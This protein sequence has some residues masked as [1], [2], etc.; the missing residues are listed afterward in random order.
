M[1]TAINTTSS[2]IPPITAPMTTVFVIVDVDDRSEGD[3]DVDDEVDANVDE[4][5]D[6]VGGDPDETGNGVVG[7]DVSSRY[8]E[9]SLE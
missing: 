1:M 6:V 9:H 5:N 3:E 7:V 4:I 2:K 8:A